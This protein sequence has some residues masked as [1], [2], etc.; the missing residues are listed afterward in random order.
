MTQAPESR[1]TRLVRPY[2]TYTLRDALDVPRA[3][4]EVNAGLAFDR[5]MLA[6]ALGTTPK[7]S[8]F[9][10]RLNASA[11]YGLTEGGYND[12]DIHLTNLGEAIVASRQEPERTNAMVAAATTPKTF[13]SF[14]EL[15]E[16]RGLP[17]NEYLEN[18][19]R[20]D[21]GVHVEL[22][23]ECLEI[24]LDNGEFAG[25]VR[26]NDG[27]YAVRLLNPPVVDST[28]S[29]AE[30]QPSG[31]VSEPAPPYPIDTD[32]RIDAL[33]TVASANTESRI[34][35]G[36]VGDSEAVGRIIS[37]LGEFGIR[38]VNPQPTGAQS[39]GPLVSSEVSAAMRD[40]ASAV[41]V[42]GGDVRKD[43]MYRMMGMLG[44]AS[45]LFQGRIVLIC[46]SG[47]D[48]D[49]GASD[50]VQVAIDTEFP[51]ESMLKIFA[52]LHNAGVIKVAAV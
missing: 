24:L 35:V 1:R 21:L 15:F 52:A 26:E 25:I 43:G 40:C 5:E 28:N 3:I 2:P 46:E 8:A 47:A 7:S 50:L 36:S 20:R 32:N 14:Y 49:I 45:A 42:L 51:G 48:L 12:A 6:S 37:M 18:I 9:T 33:H 30:V 16:G 39:G 29:R 13:R 22:T 11:A 10:M 27:Q 41:L 44:A 4:Y 17:A 34:F 38:C 19:L 31:L 23:R